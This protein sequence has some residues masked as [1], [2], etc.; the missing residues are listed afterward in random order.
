[1]TDSRKA[2][3]TFAGGCFWCM[4]SPFDKEDGV[5]DTLVGY[6]GGSLEN[7]TY[8]DVSA[9]TTGHA[10]AVQV[11]Y[12]PSIVSYERLL[13]LFWQHIDPLD[14]GGQFCDRGS[15]YRSSIFY[16]DEEQKRLAEASRDALNAS[17][18]LPGSIVTPIVPADKFWL[19]EDY[20]QD[21]YL[22][23]PIRYRFYR[24]GCARDRRLNEL[25]GETR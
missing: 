21:Y 9:G 10:E 1:M 15:Q 18:K 3:A 13:E 7:P 11:I 17:G 24:M 4:Q 19:A 23:N 25:W 22:N 6:T 8:K 20:H 5:L 14:A 12:D 2:V 16:H